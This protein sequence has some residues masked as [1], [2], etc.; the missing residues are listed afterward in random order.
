[1]FLNWGPPAGLHFNNFSSL[2]TRRVILEVLGWT[3]RSTAT[4]VAGSNPVVCSLGYL[5]RTLR[6]RNIRNWS[7]ESPSEYGHRHLCIV[8]SGVCN[9]W[10]ARI[11]LPQARMIK[12]G[13]QRRSCGRGIVLIAYPNS[14]KRGLNRC[15]SRNSI[16]QVRFR[17]RSRLQLLKRR[18][19]IH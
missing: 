18:R 11:K 5:E 9:C 6:L 13:D 12:N 15:L 16:Q 2:Q 10:P 14:L 7:C 4:I 17:H 1:M 8:S 3:P 19:K